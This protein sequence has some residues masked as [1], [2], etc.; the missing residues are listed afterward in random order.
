M[1]CEKGVKIKSIEDLD[2]LKKPDN[3]FCCRCGCYLSCDNKS[4]WCVFD[5]PVSLGNLC[6]DCEKEQHILNEK[7][8]VDL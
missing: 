1:S 4:E 5:T 3:N 6:V 7:A 8:E 2:N